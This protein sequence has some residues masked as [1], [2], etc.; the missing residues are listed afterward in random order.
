MT[1]DNNPSLQYEPDETPLSPQMDIKWD[2]DRLSTM[3]E[4]DWDGAIAFF[5]NIWRQYETGAWGE[6]GVEEIKLLIR[7]FL[8]K[9]RQ[10]GGIKVSQGQISALEAMMHDALF[11]ANRKL[12]QI[13]K[14]QRKYIPLRNGLYNLET[15]QLE[16]HRKELYFTYQLDFD[17]DEDALCPTFKQYLSTSLVTPDGEP[18]HQLVDF[19]RAALAYSM[20]ARTDLKASFWLLGKPDAGKSTFIA[21]I[22]EFLGALHVSIDMGQMGANQFMLSSLIGKRVATCTEAEAGAMISDG[23]YKAISGGSDAIWVDVKNKEG[24]SF[25]PEAKL[26]WA[27]NNAPRTR[28]RSDAIFNRLKIIPFNRSVPK[29]ERDPQLLQ[30]LL[31]EKSGI[32]TD[33]MW[34]YKRLVNAGGFEIPDQCKTVLETYRLQNDTE[35]TFAMECLI[36][37]P[38]GRI[39]TTELY[40]AY[41]DWCIENGFRPKQRNEVS[42]DWERLG[43]VSKRS[44]GGFHY[45]H[46]ASL[47]TR[48]ISLEDDKK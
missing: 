22:R 2:D 37:E 6:R 17:Y 26:W 48:Q 47:K 46:G 39:Q 40:N 33:L 18:D 12:I 41:K 23:L 11:V 27:M 10:R 14:E 1:D 44:T 29:S 3:L 45:W 24:I 30:K 43:L 31:A 28:D 19:V 25:I 21:F 35:R 16:P 34:A 9:F 4:R 36:K 32:F 42:Q 20:T 7:G 38:N 15:Q 13:Q 5:Y 8:R